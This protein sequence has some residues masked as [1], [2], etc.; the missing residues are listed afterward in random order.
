MSNLLSLKNITKKY[1]IG[2]N[3]LNVLNN[4]NLEIHKGELVSIIGQSGC[5]KS[6]LM[7]IIG[8][9]DKPSSGSYFIEGRKVDY[10]ND[11][12]ISEL[13]N[14]KIGFVFQQ[15]YLISTLTAIENVKLPLFYRRVSIEESYERAMKALEKVGMKD[16]YN[17]KP[18]EMSGGQQQRV[19]IARAIV[20]S[21]E[22]ILA[23]EPTGALDSETSNHIMD[24]LI[25]LNVKE[26]KTIIIITHDINIA[27]RCKTIY[28]MKDGILS[29]D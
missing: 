4:I 19:A 13:R 7:N 24:L 11:N 8:L 2:P 18:T 25:E 10:S 15:Y 21:P 17:H 9:L 16:R 12:Y 3:V 28:K 29:N 1:K 27:K 5:G 22:I 20:G 26:H 14:R 23:D 6:T